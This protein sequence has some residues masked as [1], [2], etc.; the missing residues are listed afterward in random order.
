MYLRDCISDTSEARVEPLS[1][2]SV[3]VA[4]VVTQVLDQQALIS[5]ARNSQAIAFF[6]SACKNVELN[7]SNV[8]KETS[9]QFFKYKKMQIKPINR[10]KINADNH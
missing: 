9:N 3:T 2:K 1:S 5:S 10:Q 8:N 6:P 7:P 4:S